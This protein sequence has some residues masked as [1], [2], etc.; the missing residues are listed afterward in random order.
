MR[1]L[2]ILAG[3]I[4]L[5]SLPAKAQ[6]PEHHTTFQVFGGYSLFRQKLP[7]SYNLNGWEVSGTVKPKSWLGITGDFSG[8]Y[9][10]IIATNQHYYVFMAGPEFS[11]PGK[12]SPFAHVLLGG[13]RN[14]FGKFNENSFA[15]AL[16]GGLDWEANRHFSV[17]VVQADYIRTSSLVL[18]NVHHARISAGIVF[19]F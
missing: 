6:E 4:F 12:F 8:H 18:N 7:F 15:V 11:I 10:T 13:V 9:G 19:R 14:T 17:R 1:K 5:I 2:A 3:L 16:G